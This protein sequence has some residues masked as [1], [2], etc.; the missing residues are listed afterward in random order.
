MGMGR[1]RKL[2]LQTVVRTY[3]RRHHMYLCIQRLTRASPL[4]KE[5]SL[6]TIHFLAR[7]CAP[8]MERPSI[9]NTAR[10]AIPSILE[11]IHGSSYFMMPS[12][13]AL[14]CRASILEK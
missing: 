3:K 1:Q 8:N 10:L 12:S 6:Y 4:D 9:Q 5:M 7:K 13:I 2:A 11:A 14:I